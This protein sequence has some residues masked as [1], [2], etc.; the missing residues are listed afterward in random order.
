VLRVIGLLFLATVA[1]W[2]WL[3]IW[4]PHKASNLIFDPPLH[5]VT[6]LAMS[7]TLLS[8]PFLDELI[9]KHQFE[10][11]CK[12]NGIESSDV[13]KA[14]GKRVKVEYGERKP[15]KGTLLPTKESDVRFK[16]AETGDVLIQ[17]KDYHS[18]GGWLMRYTWLS[19][20]SNHPMLFEGNGCDQRPEVEIFQQNSITFFIQVDGDPPWL[21]SKHT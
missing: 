10:A 12:A 14:R 4:V 20:G 11:L 17:H 8:S 6:K 3:C 13:S 2:I 21:F 15:L 16:D 7:L 19:M 18:S 9:G 5:R 1:V